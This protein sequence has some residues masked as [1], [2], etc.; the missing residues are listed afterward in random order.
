MC[1]TGHSD[2]VAKNMMPDRNARLARLDQTAARKKS[3]ASPGRSLLLASNYNCWPEAFNGQ[4]YSF[5]NVI[6]QIENADV[7]AP[8]ARDYVSGRGVRPSIAYL[9]GELFFR[10]SAAISHHFGIA[11][12]SPMKETPIDK[13]YDLFF[14]MCQ[15]PTELSSLRRLKGWKERCTFK[16]A[17]VLETWS[18]LLEQSK[19]QLALL[20]DFD[21]VFVLNKESIPNLS[22]Y[23]ST[24]C[25]FLPTASDCLL[26]TPFPQPPAR[27]I[28]VYSMGRR[29][30]A[31]HEKLCQ[32]M[33]ERPDFLYRYDT[34][35]HGAIPDWA[36]HRLLFSEMLKRSKFFVAYDH[37]VGDV[38]GI[39]NFAEQSLSTRYFEGAAGGAVLIGNHPKLAEFA[40]NF[41]WDDA[42]IDLPE[43]PE[44]LPKFLLDLGKQDERLE[45]IGRESAIQCLLRHDW[46]H[47]WSAI[48]ETIGHQKSAEHE[49]RLEHLTTLADVA[50]G[51]N[52][53]RARF[54][55]ALNA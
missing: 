9:T 35:S 44:D 38:G 14:F 25:V 47:R 33:R 53:G 50:I 20:D 8:P 48:L 7:V 27:T 19:N 24:Q 31:M 45:R 46:A 6:R 54:P 26:K 12:G 23:T 55:S 11:G 1:R 42:V 22:R 40:E 15:F 30:P 21:I 43:D 49:A 36:D 17:Y 3:S 4:S 28:D 5:V 18:E 16:I 52:Q 2:G 41:D 51:S 34:M 29:S 13:D 37:R 39:K 32:M 10:S